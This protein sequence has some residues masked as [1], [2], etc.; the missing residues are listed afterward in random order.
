MEGKR[1]TWAIVFLLSVFFIGIGGYMFIEKW[2]F[3]DSLYLVVITLATVGFSET[4][5]L[6]FP[7][8]IFTRCAHYC[9]G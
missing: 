7:G 3:L 1:I 2:N 8:L 4:H 5:P 6:T 9:V